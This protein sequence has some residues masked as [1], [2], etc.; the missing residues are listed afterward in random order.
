M[1]SIIVL[2]CSED[3]DTRLEIFENE[4]KFLDKLKRCYYGVNPDCGPQF[5]TPDKDGK[6]DMDRTEGMIVIRGEIVVPQAKKVEA[7][8][9]L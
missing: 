5:V 3:G 8:W 7:D 4:Q 2:H 1:P 6:I 9:T